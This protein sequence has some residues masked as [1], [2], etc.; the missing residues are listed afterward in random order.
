MGEPHASTGLP[1]T[2]KYHFILNEVMQQEEGNTCIQAQY[3]DL[4]IKHIPT[5]INTH[6]SNSCY[7][8]GS[9]GGST[10]GFSEST[11]ALAAAN[12]PQLTL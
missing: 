12:S 5:Q 3:V 6:Q 2:D 4:S 1:C 7:G 8:P 11:Y 10:G 9:G